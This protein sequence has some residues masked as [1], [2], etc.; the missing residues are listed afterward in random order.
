[1]YQPTEN[2]IAASRHKAEAVTAIEGAVAKLWEAVEAMGKDE[3][4]HARP[5]ISKEAEEERMG[6]VAFELEQLLERLDG[7]VRFKAVSSRVTKV[8]ALGEAVA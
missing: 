5:N 4:D 2:E 8:S 7:V 3:K 1:M 6:I